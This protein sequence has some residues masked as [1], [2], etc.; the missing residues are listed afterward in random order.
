VPPDL[1][2]FEIRAPVTGRVLRVFHESGTPVMPGTAL[3][4]VGDPTDLEVEVDV[5]SADAVKIAPGARVI[6]ERWGG[7][8]PLTG[9]VRVVEPSGFLKISALGV[10]EQRV[11]V[12]IDLLGPVENRASLG[13]G[14]R[15]EARIVVWEGRNVVG[16]PLGALF[17]REGGWAVFV[18]EQ[19]RAAL[20]AVEV[21]HRNQTMAEVARGLGEGDEVI[22]HPSD[23]VKDGGKVVKRV[24]KE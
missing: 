14:Y 6:L 24:V 19:G 10:E 16:V 21:G 5:L 7:E 8:G 4:E 20:R 13:D 11:N 3:L 1:A 9:E 23:R 18:V 12:I 15:V 17:R 22:L 2:R